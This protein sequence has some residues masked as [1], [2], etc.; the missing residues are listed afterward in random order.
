MFV[1]ACIHM[2]FIKVYQSVPILGPFKCYVT[3]FSSNVSHT[4]T[5]MTL[6]TLQYTLVTLGQPHTMNLY[7]GFICQDTVVVVAVTS[8]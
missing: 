1:L 5:S 8:D 4:T 6:I 3:L 2:C 7:D